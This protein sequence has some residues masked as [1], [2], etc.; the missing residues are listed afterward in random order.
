MADSPLVLVPFEAAH[1]RRLVADR[2]VELLGQG[3]DGAMFESSGPAFTLIHRGSDRPVAAAGLVIPWR[4]VAHAW[5]VLGWDR[6]HWCRVIHREASRG[7]RWLIREHN[8]QRVECFV[9]ATYAPGIRWAAHLGFRE[10]GEMPRYGPNGE[11]FLRM[12]ILP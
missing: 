9:S 8:L 6:E 2:P 12:V 10:E 11:T 1:Y 7:L 3:G 4:G 5:A